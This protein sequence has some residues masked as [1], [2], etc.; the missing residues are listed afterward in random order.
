[1]S[2]AK[3]FWIL[4]SLLM[5]NRRALG[6][7]TQLCLCCW[8]RRRRRRST[9]QHEQ[10]RCAVVPTWAWQ[11]HKPAKVS[12]LRAMMVQRTDQCPVAIPLL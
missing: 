8:G 2:P 11:F 1:M 7:L 5:T 9:L 6:L 10:S 12:R 3:S 4:E